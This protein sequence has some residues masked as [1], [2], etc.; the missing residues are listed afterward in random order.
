MSNEWRDRLPTID[1]DRLYRT[2]VFEG[3]A[4]VAARRQ[5]RNMVLGIAATLLVVA[6]LVALVASTSGRGDNNNSAATTAGAAT[7]AAGGTA[8]TTAG[9]ATTAA[10]TT[11]GGATTTAAASGGTTTAGGATTTS[12][13]AGSEPTLLLSPTTIYEHDP[14]GRTC[15]AERLSARYISPTPVNQAELTWVVDGT[16]GSTAMTVSGKEATAT[17]G[18]FDATVVPAGQSAAITV[19][20][21]R[22]DIAGNTSEVV[23]VAELRDCPPA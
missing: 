20:V 9:A 11:V 1:E 17:I 14:Q 5:R 3:R 8:T 23:Q 18:P 4:R 7:T 19:T 15:G 12:A 13:G 6:G 10:E 21:L 2:V 22:T 16:N